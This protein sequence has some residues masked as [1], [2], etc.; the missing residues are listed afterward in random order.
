MNPGSGTAPGSGFSKK[1][2]RPSSVHA[3][4]PLAALRQQ[5]GLTLQELADTTAIGPAVWSQLERGLMTPQ[6]RH[7]AALAAVFGAPAESWRIRFVLETEH[8]DPAEASP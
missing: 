2:G 8:V 3:A 6:P 7:L 4:T 1:R 5:R